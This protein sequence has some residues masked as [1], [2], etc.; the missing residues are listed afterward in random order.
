MHDTH[1]QLHKLPKVTPA[2]L[3]RQKAERD[4]AQMLEMQKARAKQEEIARQR[5][6]RAILLLADVRISDH[7]LLDSASRGGNPGSS[8]ASEPAAGTAAA[9]TATAATRSAAS[10]GWTGDAKRVVDA[11]PSATSTAA[12]TGSRGPSKPSST[13][14]PSAGQ[15]G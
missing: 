13:R 12:A 14:R 1:M 7:I 15:S 5:L 8:A 2:D 4:A 3:S 9:A 6:V 11:C 10:S